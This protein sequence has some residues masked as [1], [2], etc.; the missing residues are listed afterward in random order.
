[1]GLLT[2]TRCEKEKPADAAFFP[3]HGG[4]KN[5]F[6]SW[7]RECRSSY[8]ANIARGKF[9]GVASDDTVRSL[10]SVV[11]C[12]ICGDPPPAGKTL[13]IDHDHSTGDIRGVLCSRCNCGLGMFRD[14]PELLEFAKVYILSSRGSPEAEHY[15][16]A[17]ARAPAD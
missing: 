10:K 16:A 2:C 15:L 9:R 12:V 11:E 6:D 1:M 14:D 3:P 17:S 4:K 8:R 7:C 5:G 13:A